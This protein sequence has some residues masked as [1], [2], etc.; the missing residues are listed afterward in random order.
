MRGRDMKKVLNALHREGGR[1]MLDFAN[2]ANQYLLNIHGAVNVLIDV[3]LDRGETP[4]GRIIALAPQVRNGAGETIL[5]IS[6]GDI[7][8][9][10]LQ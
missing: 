3:K 4:E 6:A 1:K 8:G 7:F 10:K 9:G 5:D 2:L